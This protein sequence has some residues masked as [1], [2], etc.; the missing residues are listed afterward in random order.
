MQAAGQDNRSVSGLI[1]SNLIYAKEFE[2][3]I[4]EIELQQ[5]IRFGMCKWSSY[6]V[7]SSE[8]LKGSS[9]EASFAGQQENI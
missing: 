8:L 4:K 7:R 6:A 3:E 9:P 2:S 5:Q 1:W